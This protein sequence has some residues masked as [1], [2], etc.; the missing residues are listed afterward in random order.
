MSKK[1]NL[2]T[3]SR[4]RF[5]EIYKQKSKEI[6]KMIKEEKINKLTKFLE[7]KRETSNKVEDH[8]IIDR[9]LHSLYNMSKENDR[10]ETICIDYLIKTLID[11]IEC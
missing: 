6:I 4:K 10:V 2:N 1:V 9:L 7:L 5:A 8:E 11:E 3:E